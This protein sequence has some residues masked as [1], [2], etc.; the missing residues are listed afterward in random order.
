MQSIISAKCLKAVENIPITAQLECSLTTQT[1]TAGLPGRATTQTPR[2][3][4]RVCAAAA[5]AIFSHLSLSV[6]GVSHLRKMTL[7]QTLPGRCFTPPLPPLFL[8]L[9]AEQRMEPVPC[10]DGGG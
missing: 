10:G 7:F 1:I 2:R 5:A 9:W 6:P 8:L 3:R 4:Q